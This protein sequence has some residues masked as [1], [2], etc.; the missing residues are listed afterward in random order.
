MR[1]SAMPLSSARLA[2][3]QAG[4]TLLDLSVR[5]NVQPGRLSLIER[6]K[7][8]ARPEEMARIAAA[9]GVSVET[10]FPGAL[11]TR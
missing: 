6:E 3:L 4:L 2:R 8:A 5:S 7:T 9:I 11:A 10:A 1:C